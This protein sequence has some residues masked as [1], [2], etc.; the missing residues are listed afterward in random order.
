MASKAELKKRIEEL[1]QTVKT[2]QW[3]INCLHAEAPPHRPWPDLRP[4]SDKQRK[5]IDSFALGGMMQDRRQ[6]ALDRLG[7]PSTRLVIAGDA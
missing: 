3:I 6:Y 1:E 5:E 7:E 4:L 2:Q